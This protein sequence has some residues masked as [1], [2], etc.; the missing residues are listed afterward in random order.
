M[1]RKSGLGTLSITELQREIR[2]RQ[3]RVPG[4]QRRRARLMEKVAAID[5]Q[6]GALGGESGGRRGGGRRAAG[7]SLV[8]HLKKA[9]DGKTM[10]VA[11]VADYVK[12]HGYQTSSPN[13]RTIVNA[14]LINRKHGFKRVGRGQYTTA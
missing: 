8:A 12:E 5:A 13:F 10:G 2:R 9:L 14:A 4:L 1:A 6:I 11:E 7:D 3:R